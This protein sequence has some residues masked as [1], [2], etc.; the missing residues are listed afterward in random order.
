MIAVVFKFT[1]MI[2]NVLWVSEF[3]YSRT[4]L[5]G[6]EE[7]ASAGEYG[8]SFLIERNGGLP[9]LHV[10][11][12]GPRIVFSPTFSDLFRHIGWM[13]RS[14]PYWEKQETECSPRSQPLKCSLARVRASRATLSLQTLSLKSHED[15]IRYDVSTRT[16][17]NEE[18]RATVQ[19]EYGIEVMI[20][21]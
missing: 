16:E 5:S 15:V 20:R 7:C 6:L 10:G 2:T 8:A 4:Y 3:D 13:E 19:I 17:R 12:G 18:R 9:L 11:P 21:R 1:A 14:Y